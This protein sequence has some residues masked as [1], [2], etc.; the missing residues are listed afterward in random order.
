MVSVLV[1]LPCL[2]YFDSNERRNLNDSSLFFKL[3]MC[4]LSVYERKRGILGMAGHEIVDSGRK[5][6]VYLPAIN[7]H[8][9]NSHC[10]FFSLYSLHVPWWMLSINIRVSFFTVSAC[11]QVQSDSVWLVCSS[12]SHHVW[13]GKAVHYLRYLW[14][15]SCDRHWLIVCFSSNN[16]HEKYHSKPT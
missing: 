9:C 14:N 7:Q 15:L 1:N 16:Y 2:I 3:A 12:Y 8:L 11:V 10:I 5:K 6:K 13:N 4:F